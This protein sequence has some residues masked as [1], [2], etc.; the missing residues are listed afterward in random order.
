MIEATS[1]VVSWHSFMEAMVKS[2]R[3]ELSRESMHQVRNSQAIH[4]GG[5]G[6]YSIS[7]DVGGRQ[8]S[9]SLNRQLF[10]IETSRSLDTIA[11]DCYCL[12]VL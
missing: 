9:L 1:T 11:S 6:E 4:A 3:G 8:A 7:L 12:N 5:G 10:T 2:N